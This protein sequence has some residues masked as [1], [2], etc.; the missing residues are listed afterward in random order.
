MYIAK[1]GLKKIVLQGYFL[2]MYVLTGIDLYNVHEPAH[3]GH[4]KVKDGLEIELWL[5]VKNTFKI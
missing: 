2:C 5:T 4:E 3:A 1:V